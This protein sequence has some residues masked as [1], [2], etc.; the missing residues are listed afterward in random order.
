MKSLPK[1]RSHPRVP[2]RVTS[3]SSRK[4]SAGADSHIVGIES[5]LRQAPPRFA[6][7]KHHSTHRDGSLFSSHPHHHLPG[8]PS[9]IGIGAGWVAVSHGQVVKPIA[10]TESLQ[11]EH[12]VRPPTVKE[13]TGSR[14]SKSEFA[15]DECGSPAKPCAKLQL[16]REDFMLSPSLWL[17]HLSTKTFS[18]CKGTTVEQIHVLNTHRPNRNLLASPPKQGPELGGLFRPRV[19]TLA[20]SHILPKQ[21]LQTRRCGLSSTN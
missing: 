13:W 2:Q 12:G 1:S 16:A 5:D 9:G 14:A 11:K 15:I 7:T 18:A 3:S 10:A 6:P 8:A 20:I 17:K 19:R 21:V 4:N